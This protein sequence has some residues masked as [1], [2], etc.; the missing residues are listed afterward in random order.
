M[1]N[2][3]D[4]KRFAL[5][6]RKDLLENW[7]RYLL[8]FLTLLGIMILVIT[9]QSMEHYRYAKDDCGE[10]ISDYIYHHRDM[11]TFLLIMFMVCG[12][13]FASTCMS[14]MSSKI[15]RIS[16][17][18]NP[19][20]DL[21]KYLTRWTIVTIG[22]I[23]AFIV[24]LWI[25]DILR[26]GICSARY[27]NLNIH[28]L[29]LNTLIL[30][31]KEESGVCEANLFRYLVASAASGY[32]FHQSLFILGATFWEKASFVKTFIAEMVIVLIY[33]F[34]CRWAILLSYGGF[35]GFDHVLNSFEINNRRIG[36]EQVTTI[37]LSFLSVF[38]LINWILA[39]FRF[40]ESEV[41]KRL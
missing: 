40:R 10:H 2:T 16:Y 17:L 28:F 24:A 31:K 22:Y 6:F 35:E 38:T 14:P 25:A 26:V 20:S 30:H 21:E 32:L 4:I 1:N 7:K 3:L 34:L 36:I 9:W 13:L 12:L 27:P 29:D 37:S 23:I 5:V 19:A 39:Y 11:V 41:T 18:S 8:L 33:V 15:K